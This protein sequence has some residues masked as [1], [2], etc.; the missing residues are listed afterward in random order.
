[1]WWGIDV[2]TALLLVFGLYGLVIILLFAMQWLGWGVDPHAIIQQFSKNP[3]S[4]R[5]LLLLAFTNILPTLLHCGLGLAGLWA[6]MLGPK[7][8]QA[9]TWANKVLN[10]QALGKVDAADFAD[11]LLFGHRGFNFALALCLMFW[12]GWIFSW[13]LPHGLQW[14]LSF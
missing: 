5:W 6:D 4:S 3:R 8:Q 7:S 13:L 11:Y 9:Q 2:L 12:A 10:G 14:V 1:M